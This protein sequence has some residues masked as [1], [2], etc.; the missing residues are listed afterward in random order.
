MLSFSPYARICEVPVEA[1]FDALRYVL[2][3]WGFIRC[4]RF[5]NGRP[6]GDP[7]RQSL[8][9]CAL[10]LIA[11]GIQILINPPRMPTKNAK[12]ERCQGTTSRWADVAQCAN[13]EVFRQQL[14]Y[15]VLTQREGLPSRVCGHKT[16]AEHFP[17]LFENPRRYDP[18]DFE[19]QRAYQSLSK[20]WYKRKV[21]T[22]GQIVLFGKTY[23]IG[24]QHHTK[25]IMAK[26]NAETLHWQVYDLDHKL[27]T[28]MPADNINHANLQSLSF[29]Q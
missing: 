17:A 28:S 13:L 22:S 1:V 26:F 27:I 12:V 2:W 15:A 19:L 9:P 14:E 29:C 21:S 11:M 24:H 6:F 3:R 8:T 10:R 25:Y 4:F 23:R 18:T 20:G 7:T 5:D 16:R